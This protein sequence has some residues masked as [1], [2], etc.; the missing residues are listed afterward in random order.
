M[1]PRTVVYVRSFSSIY[2]SLQSAVCVWQG[3]AQRHRESPCQSPCLFVFP[4]RRHSPL[5]RCTDQRADTCPDVLSPL[6]SSITTSHSLSFLPI[7][8]LCLCHSLS[9]SLSSHPAFS[10]TISAGILIPLLP[11]SKRSMQTRWVER[12]LHALSDPQVYTQRHYWHKHKQKANSRET[13]I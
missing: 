5:P 10:P 1:L 6:L 12:N 8:T 9:L 4:R 13:N 7:V 2:V 11:R 3:Q